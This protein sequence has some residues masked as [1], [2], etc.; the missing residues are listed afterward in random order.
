MLKIVGGGGGA[1]GVG[2]GAG[3]DP[4][5]QQTIQQQKRMK[6][7]MRAPTIM[8][9]GVVKVQLLV[10]LSLAMVFSSWSRTSASNFPDILV[11][12]F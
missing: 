8:A 12:S 9:L 7:H 6:R 3:A 2:Y 11:R 10:T 5:L 1:V 4:D